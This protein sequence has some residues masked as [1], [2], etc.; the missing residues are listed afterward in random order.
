[1]APARRNA[2]PHRVARR[3]PQ[4]RLPAFVAIDLVVRARSSLAPLEA[5]FP[6]AY[7]P[8]R[9]RDG[10]PDDRWLIAQALSS[11]TAEATA[12]KL[13]AIVESLNGDAGRCWRQASSRVFDVGV[14][15]GRGGRASEDVQL[16]AATLRRFAA[17]RARL[18]VTVYPLE[19]GA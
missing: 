14:Q 15:A 2:R 19:S 17:S 1:M 6:L 7:Y 3:R 4:E 18:Q 5:A 10:T 8:R 13:L 16:S 11:P 9:K 12:R